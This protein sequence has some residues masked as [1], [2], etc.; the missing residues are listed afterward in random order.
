[1]KKIFLLVLCAVSTGCMM[2]V[3]QPGMGQQQI[4][5]LAQRWEIDINNAC[6][7]DV[8]FR[9]RGS[10]NTEVAGP[11]FGNSATFYLT[12]GVTTGEQNGWVRVSA[13][14][15]GA[16]LGSWKRDYYFSSYNPIQKD[17]QTINYLTDVPQ[18]GGGCPR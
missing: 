2:T 12:R 10:N 5:A 16:F 18:S 6:G 13:Y 9:I 8:T 15:N 7:Q 4:N 1:M 14:R 17:A 11:T 3:Y